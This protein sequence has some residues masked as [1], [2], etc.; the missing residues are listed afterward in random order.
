V[1]VTYT[2]YSFRYE[3]IFTD[4]VKSIL[5]SF[6][7]VK[8]KARQDSFCQTVLV[9]IKSRQVQL[10]A[11]ADAMKLEKDGIKLTSIIHRLEDFFGESSLNYDAIAL[12]LVLFLSTT[13]KLRL[14]IDR[15]N[16][17]FGTC[18]VNILMVLVS[19][20]SGHVPLY[21]ELLYNNNGN[22]N[23]EQRI[24]IFGKI[25][26]LI[27]VDSIGVVI[28]DRDGAVLTVYWSYLVKISKRQGH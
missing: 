11:I 18:C 4:K 1:C 9:L 15:T 28:G 20:G 13:S 27:G 12:L 24:A 22:S 8:N 3:K 14:S 21:F 10:P 16:W 2:K 6:Q 17:E 25:I 19:D 5:S 23:A 7:I 26:A